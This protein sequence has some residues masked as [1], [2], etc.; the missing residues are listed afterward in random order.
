MGNYGRLTVVFDVYTDRLYRI[1]IDN[2]PLGGNL[3]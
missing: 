3:V 2:L 1:S